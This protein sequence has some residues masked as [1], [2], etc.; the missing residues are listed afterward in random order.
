MIGLAR[1]IK[2]TLDAD[3]TDNSTAAA[4]L[5]A[6]PT[7]FLTADDV[8][9]WDW[10]CL[11][12]MYVTDATGLARKIVAVRAGAHEPSGPS[13]LISTLSFQSTEALQGD[14]SDDPRDQVAKVRI[15]V[16]QHS[17]DEDESLIENV[18]ERVCRLL[19]FSLRWQYCG[20]DQDLDIPYGLGID[21]EGCLR[22]TFLSNEIAENNIT[23]RLLMFRAEYTKIFSSTT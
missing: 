17:E 21:P 18:S 3:T 6:N 10:Q 7:K 16:R 8:P 5:A 4:I 1:A 23:Q 14:R 22:M 13:I 15:L 12:N 19:D 20:L 2:A 9:K 11:K